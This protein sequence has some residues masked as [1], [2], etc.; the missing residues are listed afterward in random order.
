MFAQ[1]KLVV[2]WVSFSFWNVGV[3]LHGWKVI[4]EWQ[5][6]FV[7]TWAGKRSRRWRLSY[8]KQTTWLRETKALRLPRPRSGG[9]VFLVR[10]LCTEQL[11]LTEAWL[12]VVNLLGVGDQRPQWRRGSW[13]VCG[14]CSV[15]ETVTASKFGESQTCE[16][17]G[18]A[19][20]S[21]TFSL[22]WADTLDI[23]CLFKHGDIHNSTNLNWIDTGS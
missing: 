9:E 12:D 11:S 3:Y 7:C 8:I 17:E 16:D 13:K 22:K 18:Q 10:S 15:T 19:E 4:I 5:S 23:Q 21:Q 1:F 6:V 20:A 14:I 2:Q